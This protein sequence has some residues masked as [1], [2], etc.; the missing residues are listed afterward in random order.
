MAEKLTPRQQ[1]QRAVLD[2]LP[3]KFE[4]LHRLIEELAAQRADEVAIRRLSRIL[5][6]AKSS[7]NHAGLNALSD[8]FGLMSMLTRRGG[9]HQMKVR[10]LREGLASLKINY[11]GALRQATTAEPGAD[12]SDEEKPG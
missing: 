8:T 9:G 5:D 2:P 6:E 3:R 7:A 10:G 11:E 12:T 1:A 4:T